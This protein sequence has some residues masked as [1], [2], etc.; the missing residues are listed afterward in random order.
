MQRHPTSCG[1][2]RLA[3]SAGLQRLAP[4]ALRCD[5]RLGDPAKDAGAGAEA[6]S[7]P[8]ACEG[9]VLF[10]RR[11]GGGAPHVDK[12]LLHSPSLHSQLLLDPVVDEV[13][14]W[15]Q[16]EP[17]HPRP[18]FLGQRVL[19]LR[20]RHEREVVPKLL[21]F[22]AR[23][24]DISRAR[25]FAS[26]RR[27]A[28][29]ARAGFC[30]RSRVHARRVTGVEFIPGQ[31]KSGPYLL[32]EHLLEHPARILGASQL[33]QRRRLRQLAT[34]DAFRQRQR[35]AALRE[36]EPRAPEVACRFVGR[37]RAE[38]ADWRVRAGHG[39][40]WRPPAARW[41]CPSRPEGGDALP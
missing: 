34:T 41:R 31:R 12:K 21:H 1:R 30:A 4:R 23:A 16:L 38:R 9:L 40:G 11:D 32:S 39:H 20:P 14:A 17:W 33:W 6:S 2:R 26:R 8:H 13:V 19:R 28:R 27:H 22:G 3:H 29:G 35:Q 7:G 5:L 18:V 36:A 15:P 24:C 25:E 37:R 10:P